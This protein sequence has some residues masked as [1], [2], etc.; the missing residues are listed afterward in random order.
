M[1]DLEHHL[2]VSHQQAGRYYHSMDRFREYSGT[3]YSLACGDCN[4]VL[5]VAEAEAHT[6]GRPTFECPWCR[7]PQVEVLVHQ[8]VHF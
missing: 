8:S 1:R 5:S 4:A 2:Q 6:C 3:N 7:Q